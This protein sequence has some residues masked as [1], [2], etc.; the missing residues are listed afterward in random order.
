MGF[1]RGNTLPLLK[2]HRLRPFYGSGLCLGQA[3]VYF[4]YENLQ[5]MAHLAEIKL[6]ES[7]PIELSY[8]S[9]FAAKG[10]IS[11]ETF[12]LSLG[13]SELL[14]L[15]YSQFEGSEIIFDLNES[16][17]P[18]ELHNRFDAIFNHGTMEHIFHI[19][20]FL[21]NVFGMLKTGGRV[22]HGA[23][24]S[25][26]MDHG[27]YMFSPTFFYDYYSANRWHI[28]SIQVN[29]YINIQNQE[30]EPP[31]YA[32]YEPGIFDSLSSGGLDG[33]AYGVICIATKTEES[34]GNI[35]PQQ[36]HYQ[37]IWKQNK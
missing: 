21:N 23:P 37:K 20:N 12:L 27:F 8:R 9:D 36:G 24:A 2:E 13:F 10:Y 14:A 26:F 29:H 22:I 3:D 7:V 35:V 31:F 16:I 32:D 33:K 30:T 15:D 18:E 1:V 19:P 25:N 4:T 11:R 34:T 28:N 5:R 17:L 6:I